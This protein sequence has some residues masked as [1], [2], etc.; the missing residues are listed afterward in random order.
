MFFSIYLLAACII[1]FLLELALGAPFI[2]LFAFDSATAL[3]H[4]WQFVTAIFL[5]GGFQHLLFNGLALFFFGPTLEQKIGGKRFLALFFAAGIIGNIAFM[6]LSPTLSGLGAS[7][8]IFGIL[9][10]LAV[11]APN[12]TIF[13]MFIPM[14]MWIAAFF[15]VVTEYITLLN[16][17]S[18]IGAAAHLGGLF[19]GMLAGYW[20]KTKSKRMLE[21]YSLE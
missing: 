13:V 9:G 1:V 19:F 4:P 7:G 11:M 16:P 2:K 6:F 21:Q 12:L 8:A 15:W 3:S 17:A 18:G 10:A 14:P 20:L 5:H